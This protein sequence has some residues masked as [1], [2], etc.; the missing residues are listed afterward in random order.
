MAR[1][2]RFSDNRHGVGTTLVLHLAPGVLFAAS[3]SRRGCGP[4]RG[5]YVVR[6]ATPPGCPTGNCCR[7]EA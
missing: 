1:D 6:C 4:A 2:D 7:S 5:G 3:R